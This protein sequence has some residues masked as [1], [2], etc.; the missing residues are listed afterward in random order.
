MDMKTVGKWSFL[1]GAVVAIVGAWLEF[2]NEWVTLILVI[3]SLLVGWFNVGDDKAKGFLIAMLALVAFHAVLN[4]FKVIGG[5]L[6]DAF[7][8]FTTFLSPAAL[9][10]AAKAAYEAA[11]G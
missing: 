9:L 6:G 8:A 5:Y 10:V 4:D 7:T 11:K 1:I 3:L 2:S